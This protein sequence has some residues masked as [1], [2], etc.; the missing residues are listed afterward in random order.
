MAYQ[1]GSKGAYDKWAAEVGDSS[2]RWENFLPF[3]QKSVTFLPP[4]DDLRPANATPT[5]DIN[6]FGL[7]NGPLKLTYP[8]FANSWSSWIHLA[9]KELG[10]QGGRDFVDGKLLG[11]G[12]VASSIDRESQTRMSSETSY[13]RKALLTLTNLSIYKTTLAKRII[14]DKNKRATAVEVDTAGLK[15]TISASKEVIVSSGAVSIP[16]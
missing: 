16:L 5:Y 8:N 9:F 1:R 3:F 4:N 13:L 12:Y 15:Y 10:F 14:F 2:Y 11:Y 7:Q 6:A